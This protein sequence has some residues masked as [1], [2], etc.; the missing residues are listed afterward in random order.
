MKWGGGEY[1][2]QP[3]SYY[4]VPQT[5]MLFKDAKFMTP[6][7]ADILLKKKKQKRPGHEGVAGEL[8]SSTA[9]NSEERDHKRLARSSSSGSVCKGKS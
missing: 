2:T 3:S 9:E 4:P 1:F 6:L 8:P 7:P 5:G